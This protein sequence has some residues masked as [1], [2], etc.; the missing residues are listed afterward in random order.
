MYL[1]LSSSDCKKSHP[2]NNAWDFTVDLTTYLQ[3]NDIWEC[4]LTDINYAGDFGDLYVFT[5]L[6]AS[7][8]VNNSYLPILRVT[9]SASVFNAPYFIEIPRNFIERIRVY[10]RT[11]NGNPPSFTPEHLTCTLRLR[12]KHAGN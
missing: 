7:S 8:Y 3:L 10:I 9:S 2:N 1:F 11:R 5:D 12:R 4:A 6:C